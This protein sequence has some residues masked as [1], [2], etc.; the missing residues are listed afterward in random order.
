MIAAM[1]LPFGLTHTEYK[2]RDG[3]FYLIETA[4][5]GGG[6][7]IS[8]DI[9][10]LLSGID[11]N[12]LLINMLTGCSD[13]II[14]SN[15]HECAVLGFFDFKPG[16]IMAIGGLEEALSMAGAYDIKLEVR[17]GDTLGEAL[18]DRSRCGYYILFAD[19]VQE[20]QA[21]ERRLKETIRVVSE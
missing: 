11:C 14:R 2:Y 13:E 1:R 7:K 17:V 18:D 10:K 8:S 15:H 9:T 3:K 20:L 12:R 4:A 19:S 21:R 6:T 16:R 5:R